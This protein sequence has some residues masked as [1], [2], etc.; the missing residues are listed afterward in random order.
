MS[1]IYVPEDN[2]CNV[3]QIKQMYTLHTLLNVQLQIFLYIQFK[4]KSFEI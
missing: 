2:K 1:E 4:T 3:F